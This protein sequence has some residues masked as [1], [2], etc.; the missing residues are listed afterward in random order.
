MLPDRSTQDR[1][2]VRDNAAAL[3]VKLINFIVKALR[4]YAT[5]PRESATNQFLRP[6]KVTEEDRFFMKKDNGGDARDR[7]EFIKYFFRK[8]T[9]SDMSLFE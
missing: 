6:Q 3:R 4:I 9:T 1:S 2:S 7:I 8:G 5:S